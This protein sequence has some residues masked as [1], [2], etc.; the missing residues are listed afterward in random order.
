MNH[1]AIRAL[2]RISQSLRL[3]LE[4]LVEKVYDYNG[5]GFFDGG[6]LLLADALVQWSAGDIKPAGIVR[7]RFAGQVD[8]WVGALK[9]EGEVVFIDANGFQDKRQLL[10]YWETDECLGPMML[11]DSPQFDEEGEVPRDPVFSAKLAS[12]LTGVLGSYENW[13]AVLQKGLTQASSLEPR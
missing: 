11:V 8:H 10:D 12:E 13:R 9:L 6:C 2:N 1:E 7:T 3:S 5:C 4:D